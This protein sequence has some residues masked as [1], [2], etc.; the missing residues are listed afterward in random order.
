MASRSN[1]E[2]RGT[3][4]NGNRTGPRPQVG[5]ADA[6]TRRRM[7]D[8]RLSERQAPPSRAKREPAPATRSTGVSPN[9]YRLLRDRGKQIDKE[10]DKQ[11]R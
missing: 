9:A 6:A 10:V 1:L 4:R 3:D 8:Q 11:S 7:L 2:N 5:E